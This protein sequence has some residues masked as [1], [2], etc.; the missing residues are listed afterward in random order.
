MYH[1]SN[2]TANIVLQVIKGLEQHTKILKSL[3]EKNCSPRAKNLVVELEGT[4]VS[5]ATTVEK[6]SVC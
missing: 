6:D 2:G 3:V 4:L 1:T 5:I